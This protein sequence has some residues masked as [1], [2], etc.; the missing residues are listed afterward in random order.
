M[1]ILIQTRWHAPPP[2]EGAYR[3]PEVTLPVR[4]E[5][6]P[7]RDCVSTNYRLTQLDGMPISRGVTV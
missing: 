7:G 5:V 2:P 3:L 1:V 4:I 6:D